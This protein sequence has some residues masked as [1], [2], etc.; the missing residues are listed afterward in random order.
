[1]KDLNID[2][3]KLEIEDTE[4]S[5]DNVQYADMA[6]HYIFQKVKEVFDAVTVRNLEIKIYGDNR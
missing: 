2:V 3:F 4:Y 6:V 1:M 5:E